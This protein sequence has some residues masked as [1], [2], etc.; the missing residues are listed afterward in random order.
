MMV[1]IGVEQG[2]ENSGNVGAHVSNQLIVCWTS[3]QIFQV[4]TNVT[5]NL[6]SPMPV[7]CSDASSPMMSRIPTVQGMSVSAATNQPRMSEY[8]RTHGRCKCK[9]LP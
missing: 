8:Y 2:E 9:S 7:V 3:D 1:S 4:M 6:S 5:T